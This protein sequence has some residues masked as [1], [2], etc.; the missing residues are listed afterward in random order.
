MHRQL[1]N[2]CPVTP[3][4]LNLYELLEQ[5]LLYFALFL[6]LSFAKLFPCYIW[7]LHKR[8][9]KYCALLDNFKLVHEKG[10][11]L[12]L[13]VLNQMYLFNVIFLILDLPLDLISSRR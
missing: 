10:N 11:V 9:G 7:N 1:L 2:W 5:I 12:H 8:F 6:S 13:W 4:P 3:L